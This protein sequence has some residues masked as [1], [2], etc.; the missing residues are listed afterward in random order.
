MAV[1][2]CAKCSGHSWELKEVVPQGSNFRWFFVQCAACGA[3]V[4]VV[5]FLPNSALMHK[6]EAVEKAVGSIESQ[7][8]TIDHNIRMLAQ[9]TR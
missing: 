8:S 4:G 9:R 5:D 2:T 3:P 6:L 7:L 1:S